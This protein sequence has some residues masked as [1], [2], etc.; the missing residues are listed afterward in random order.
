MYKQATLPDKERLLEDILVLRQTRNVNEEQIR[1]LK[2][3]YARLKKYV[4]K[5]EDQVESYKM[6]QQPEWVKYKEPQQAIQKVTDIEGAN[7]EIRKL[8][9]QI[10]V[11]IEERQ[12]FKVNTEKYKSRAQQM[13]KKYMIVKNTRDQNNDSTVQGKKVPDNS[14]LRLQATQ[15]KAALKQA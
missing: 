7:E 1:I 12:F 3:Q 8:K 14:E 9:G 5:L 2:V 10:N 11:L 15:A 4:D 13:R 6:D